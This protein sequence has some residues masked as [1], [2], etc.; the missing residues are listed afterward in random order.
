MAPYR[1]G[2]V[3]NDLFMIF[4]FGQPV[5]FCCVGICHLC[6]IFYTTFRVKNICSKDH[7]ISKSDI[8]KNQDISKSDSWCNII[9]KLFP[10]TH[11]RVSRET[12]LFKKRLSY[13]HNTE[14]TFFI[15]PTLEL[16]LELGPLER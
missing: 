10:L 16:P 14:R 7:D 9:K 8:S 11:L 6:G 5:L 15:H 4:S 2:K 1:Q 13:S 12:C 3:F